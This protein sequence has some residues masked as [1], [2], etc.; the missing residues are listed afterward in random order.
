MEGVH[1]VWLCLKDLVV[2]A[3]R[4]HQVAGLMQSKSQ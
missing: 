1:M 3:L 4:V 2:K